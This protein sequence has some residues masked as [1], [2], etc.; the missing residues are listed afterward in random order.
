PHAQNVMKSLQQGVSSIEKSKH[1]FEKQLNI[2]SVFS[3]VSYVLPRLLKSFHERHPSI[4]PVIFT[5]HSDQVLKM[6]L[7]D[8]VSVGIVRS[9]LH[10]QIE[11]FPLIK[12]DMILAFH[13][14]HPF[15]S[16]SRLTI[17]D[18]AAAA[19]I[20][21]KHETIDWTLIHNAFERAR[22]TPNITLEVDSIDGVKQMVK[23]NLGISILP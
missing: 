7:N 18:V 13:P 2:A 6:V 11:S 1:S 4:K 3:G 10:A 20:L 5:G 21:F 12:D 14:G 17:E 22:L 16:K 8:E 9:L 15:A 19:F 23:E